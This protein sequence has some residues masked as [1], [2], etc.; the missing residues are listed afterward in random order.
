MVREG[1]M[2]GGRWCLCAKLEALQTAV[3]IGH[4]SFPHQPTGSEPFTVTVTQQSSS[5]VA[6]SVVTHTC[7]A[8]RALFL[9]K[10]HFKAAGELCTHSS[11]HGRPPGFRPRAR[12]ALAAASG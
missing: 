6:A 1:R 3:L 10:P 9:I 5:F 7:K 12:R 4:G 2:A 11:T 8:L